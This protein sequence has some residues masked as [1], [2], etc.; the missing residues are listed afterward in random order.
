M[1]A[2][3]RPCAVSQPA[4]QQRSEHQSRLET[5]SNHSLFYAE[6]RRPESSAVLFNI[7]REIV[8]RKPLQVNLVV[9]RT[10]DQRRHSE[11]PRFHQ[12]GENL[13]CK[14]AEVAV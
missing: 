1:R 11:A 10:S 4:N 8:G 5:E 9:Q 2:G 13:S 12:R 3:G 14:A 6:T 7:A